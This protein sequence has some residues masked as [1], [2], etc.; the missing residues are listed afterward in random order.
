ML[1]YCPKCYPIHKE[2]SNLFYNDIKYINIKDIRKRIKQI[3]KIY[4]PLLMNTLNKNKTINESLALS[5]FDCI[6]RN[7]QIITLLNILLSNCQ[8]Y[9]YYLSY[10]IKVSLFRN[11]EDKL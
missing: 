2:H 6:K 10:S 1:E 5:F 9:I 7:K 3:E 4:Q 8:C 11:T